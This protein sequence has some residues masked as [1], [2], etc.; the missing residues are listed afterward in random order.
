MFT[1]EKHLIPKNPFYKK[2]FKETIKLFAEKLKWKWN[3]LK[4]LQIWIKVCFY[5][6]IKTDSYQNHS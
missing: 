5:F 3:L 6:K 2:W 4:H 1:F